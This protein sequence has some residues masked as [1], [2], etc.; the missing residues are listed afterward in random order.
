MGLPTGHLQR[1]VGRMSRLTAMGTG[2]NVCLLKM[3]SGRMTICRT[4]V[5]QIEPPARLHLQ[6]MP[7]YQSRGL[8]VYV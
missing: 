1:E 3:W 4:S 5:W 2:A 8:S 6:Q 7:A